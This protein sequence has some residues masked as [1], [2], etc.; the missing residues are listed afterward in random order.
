M[1]CCV[2][3]F[4]IALLWL[5]KLVGGA[6]RGITLITAV[7][8]LALVTAVSFSISA[9]ALREIQL[10]RQLANS[11]PAIISAEAGAETAMFFRIRKLPTYTTACPNVNTQTL[12]SGTTFFSFCSDYYDNP[13]IFHTFTTNNEVILLFDP[14]NNTNQ[15]AGYSALDIT[16]TSTVGG[17]N[18]MQVKAYDI[19]QPSGQNCGTNPVC[20]TFSVPGTGSI[21]LNPNKSYAVFLVP[22]TSGEV[23]GYL[24]GRDAG[25]NIIGVPSKSPRLSSTGYKS[26]VLRKL[27]VILKR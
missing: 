21:N 13:Y 19:N 5:K 27:E 2:W 4:K 18:L 9:L 22:V 11:E 17:V 20:S 26:S 15:A 3:P 23:G 14:I 24:T 12:S 6:N 10:S 25:N 1:S 7:M 16:A 8:V